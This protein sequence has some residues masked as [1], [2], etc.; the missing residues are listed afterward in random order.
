M[1][2]LAG[3]RARIVILGGGFGGAYCA[4]TLA[5]LAGK[6]GADVTLID[7]NN[8]VLFY[9]LLVEAGVGSIE[10]RHVVIPTRKFTGRKCE[11]RMAEVASVDLKLGEIVLSGQAERIHFDHLIL[12]LGSITREPDIPGLRENGFQM[13]T[14]V[15]AIGLRDRAIRHL[16][17]A[18]SISDPEKRREVL[19]CITVGANFTGVEFAGEYFQF[20]REA[21]KSYPNVREDE[22]RMLVL[23]FS[24]KILSATKPDLAAWCRKTM[25]GWGIE[26]RTK[27]TLTEV[28][29]DYAVA[30]SGERIPTHTV[31]WAAGIAPNPLLKDIEGLPLN[32]HGYI[33]CEPD[34]RVKG[35]QNVWAVGDCATVYDPDGKP[36]AAT[37]QTAS[38]EGPLAG[39]NV[40]RALQGERT[41]P[42]RYH[43]LGSFA[44]IGGKKAAADV[45]GLSVKGFA[46]W[47]IYRGAYWAK[48]PTLGMK[49]RLLADWMTELVF[50]N[51]PVQL[52]VHTR[53]S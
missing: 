2:H 23:E 49:V 9:P 42:F 16:E 25:E 48:M 5:K 18:N 35:F 52:G 21:A 37:A 22:I 51:E 36:Y 4:K 45:L 30:S 33:D 27:S 15:D 13:K 43:E 17:Q 34:L 26:I 20:L 53:N 24:D 28:G 47:V 10:A 32:S 29:P 39:R 3:E 8:Y 11:F 44:A 46:G 7:R 14:L 1:A 38:R 12:S 19:T 50:R 40:L 6:A 31:L 41:E